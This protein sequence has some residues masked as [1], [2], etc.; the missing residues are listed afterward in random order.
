[1]LI[2]LGLACLTLSL[3]LMANSLGIGG[4]DAEALVR[5]RVQTAQLVAAQC[6][7]AA[8]AGDTATMIAI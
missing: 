6:S 4:G 2:S 3:V 5:A 7:P 1:M 8:E